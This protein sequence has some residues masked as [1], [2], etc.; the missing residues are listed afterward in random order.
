MWRFYE[1]LQNSYSIQYVWKNASTNC[2][3]LI[4]VSSRHVDVQSDAFRIL[5]NIYDEVCDKT[6]YKF[7]QNS[8]IINI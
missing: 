2:A 5:S 7:L 6:R 3:I 4:E 1:I 8:F